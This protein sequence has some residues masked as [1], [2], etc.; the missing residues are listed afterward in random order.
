MVIVDVVVIV[1]CYWVKCCYI[2]CVGGCVVLVEVDE[3]LLCV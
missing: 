3:C 2:V 1:D